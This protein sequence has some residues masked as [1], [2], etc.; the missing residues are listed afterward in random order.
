VYD[1]AMLLGI[2]AEILGEGGFSMLL[3]LEL[4]HLRYPTVRIFP[5]I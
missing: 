5:Q 4:Y 2:R 3:T 1:A